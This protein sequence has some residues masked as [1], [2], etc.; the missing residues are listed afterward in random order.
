MSLHEDKC[1]IVILVYVGGGGLTSRAYTV[2]NK[3]QPKLPK[4][5]KKQ[6]QKLSPLPSIFNFLKLS[7]DE[8][9]VL[10]GTLREIASNYAPTLSINSGENIFV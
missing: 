5:I 7:W 10:Q 3:I 9:V 8:I 1:G 2:F 6:T 4:E